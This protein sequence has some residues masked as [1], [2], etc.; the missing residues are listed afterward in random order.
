MV[1]TGVLALAAAGCSTGFSPATPSSVGASSLASAS[2]TSV[3]R[4]TAASSAV[5]ATTHTTVPVAFAFAAGTCGLTTHVAAT[6]ELDITVHS[7]A[8]PSGTVRLT[9]LGNAHGTA[10][11]DDGSQYV[12]S[13]NQ[14]VVQENAL[15]DPIPV[16]IT[17]VFELVGLGDAPNVRTGFVATLELSGG[18]PLNPAFKVI[19]GNP[20]LCDPL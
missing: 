10:V 8:M 11:G 19:R 14:R 20:F 7:V 16:S 12:F 13:Y 3:S 1:F 15:A 18:Q 5:A 4:A 2:P 17:D 9:I 6:G